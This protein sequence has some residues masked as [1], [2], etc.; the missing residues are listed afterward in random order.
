MGKIK[1]YVCI[2]VLFAISMQVWA[3]SNDSNETTSGAATI[4]SLVASIVAL[5]GTFVT[6]WKFKR[7]QFTDTITKERLNFI[8]DWREYATCFCALLALKNESFKVDEFEGHKLEYYYYKLLLMC[9]STRPESYVDIE[10]VNLLNQLYHDKGKVSDEQL[11][12]FVALMQANISLEWKGTDL[13]S[14]NG[15]L[16]EEEKEKIRFDC[17]ENYKKWL[18]MKVNKERKNEKEQKVSLNFLVWSLVFYCLSVIGIIIGGGIIANDSFGF[19]LKNIAIS[20]LAIIFLFM[21]L[22]FSLRRKERQ[23]E[24]RIEQ[25]KKLSVNH[26]ER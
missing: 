22:Y 11:E 21:G 19:W 10:V 25:L 4:V 6:Y 2:M 18:S 1:R 14:R 20:L 17:F 8:K 12:K 13:E 24:E 3:A 7:Q 16:S 26:C 15:Q 23:R 5:I 9:N